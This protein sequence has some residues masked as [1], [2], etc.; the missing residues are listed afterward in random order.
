MH[1][2]CMYVAFVYA[3][4]VH[5]LYIYIYVYTYIYI[6]QAH[7]PVCSNCIFMDVPLYE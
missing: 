3:V 1:M 4:Y 7:L 6:V 2:Y 5:K